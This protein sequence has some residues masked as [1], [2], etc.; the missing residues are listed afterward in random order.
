M[1]DS[2]DQLAAGMPRGR[3]FI[4]KRALLRGSGVQPGQAGCEFI[5]EWASLQPGCYAAGPRHASANWREGTQ[6]RLASVVQRWHATS[7][8]LQAGRSAR[9]GEQSRMVP[10][11]QWRLTGASATGRMLAA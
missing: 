11:H 8:K 9:P 10:A 5:S 3:A 1:A 7:F 4:S 2:S 6:K